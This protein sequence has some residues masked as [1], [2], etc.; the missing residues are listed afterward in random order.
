MILDKESEYYIKEVFQNFQTTPNHGRYH[1]VIKPPVV[2]KDFA[3]V[4]IWSPQQNSNID[5]MCLY[6]SEML[7]P[8][9]WTD[10][11]VTPGSVKNPRL[12]Y[13]LF[14]DFLLIQQ[15]F[16]FN[17]ENYPN[18]RILSSDV[19]ILTQHPGNTLANFN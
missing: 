10:D 13:D 6:H 9:M 8:G 1:H 7:S 18:H 3:S 4:F 15:Y 17:Q 19:R 16:N 14:S 5:L 12:L 2:K 11:L